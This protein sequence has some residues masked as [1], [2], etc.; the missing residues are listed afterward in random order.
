VQSIGQPLKIDG[1]A[2]VVEAFIRRVPLF[3]SLPDR[4]VG[5]LADTLQPVEFAPG[6]VVFHEGEYGDRFYIVLSGEVEIIKSLGAEAER[7]ISVRGPG[8]YIGE[9]SLVNRDGLRTASTRARGP[10]R[11]LEMTREDFDTLLT[12]Y[13]TLAYEMVRVLS[14]R[15]NQAHNLAT[16]DLQAKNRQ[17]T[18]AYQ[19]LQAAQAQI[20]EKEKLEHELRMAREVQASLLP[21]ALPR[22]AG[23]EFAAH[24]QPAREVGGDF[25]DFI[26]LDRPGGQGLG[27]LI[28]DVSG[29]GMPAALFMAM[30]R[31]LL[32][33]SLALAGPPADGLTQANRLIH[34]DA[35][36]GMFVTLF[37]AQLDLAAGELTYVNAGHNP[38]W[39][40]RA[41]REDWEELKRT[42]TA[43]GLFGVQ[44]LGQRAAR[45]APGDCLFLYTDGVTDAADARGQRFGVEALRAVLH[46]HRHSTAAQIVAAVDQAVAQ[47]RGDQGLFDDI[48]IVV[49]RRI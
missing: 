1:E 30:A 11:V 2:S 43:L 48:A 49:A 7:L 38:P 44:A 14:L 26:P 18:E 39:W 19:A 25:Y 40:Y 16:R 22:P 28:G 42:G 20:I 27:M 3:A 37:Y 13:P 46:A 8:D 34:A 4:E 31:S 21:R 23:W 35:G 15:L 6:Q 12:R 45:L 24:W 33:A 5:H 41:A 47:F 10:T 9:M 17:L 29:K 32:R 36:A